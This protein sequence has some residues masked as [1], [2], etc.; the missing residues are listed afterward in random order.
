MTEN[1]TKTLGAKITWGGLLPDTDPAYDGTWTFLLP[2]NLNP[3]SPSNSILRGKGET[4]VERY[5]QR[6]QQQQQP[7][8]QAKAIHCGELMKGCDFV[9][10]DAT[11]D[12]VMKKAAEH[13][14]TTHG[15]D[16]ITPELAQKVKAAIKNE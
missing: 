7:A 6:Q 1:K 2:K 8:T 9:A 10:H 11:E 15:I 5:Q 16:N 12:E 3:N 13:A 4:L 14:K